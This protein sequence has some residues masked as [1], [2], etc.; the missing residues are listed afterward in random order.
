MSQMPATTFESPTVDATGAS[1]ILIVDDNPTNL[2]VLTEALA[3]TGYETAVATSGEEA[4]EQIDYEPPDLILLDVM[5]PPGIDGFETCRRIK[6]AAHTQHLPIIFMTALTDTAQKVKGFS[7]GAADYITKPFQQAEVIARVQAQ[8]KIQQLTQTLAQQN[9]TLQTLSSQLE[10]KVEARTAELQRAQVQMIQQEKF[11]TLGQLLAGV[12][13]DINNPLS[14]LTGNITPAKDYIQDLIQIVRLYQQHCDTIIPEVETLAEEADLEFLIEDLPKLLE[15]MNLGVSR[16]RE[17]SNSLRHFARADMA[18]HMPT[19]LHQGLDN[20]LVILQHRI[21][22][23]D[24]RSAIAVEK[25]YGNLPQVN[26]FPG[27]INQVFMNLLANAID[28]FDEGLSSITT[29][30]I[31]LTTQLVG[32]GV[33]ITVQ[34]NARGIEPAICDR[35]FD[36]QFT[37]KPIGKGT[38]LGLAI[39]RQIVEEQ[40]SGRLICESQPGAGTMFR[41]C[42]PI[43]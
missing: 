17:I 36:P 24:S 2:A 42:L 21:R 7:L 22:A 37:T 12:A 39:S 26:C 38:G 10:H 8:L 3:D 4:I 9:Q 14:C 25:R 33:E 35:L 19:D 31:I 20:T 28:A 43:G 1:L 30:Q 11:S 15:S 5:M 41:V 27:P 16:I 23:T 13:H 29:P 32:N 34:D 18:S 40:H 6:A